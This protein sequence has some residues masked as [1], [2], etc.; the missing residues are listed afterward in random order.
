M[1]RVGWPKGEKRSVVRPSAVIV[2]TDAFAAATIAVRSSAVT[3]LEPVLV[4]VALAGF[5]VEATGVRGA[6]APTRAAVPPEARTA[7]RA[8]AATTLPSPRLLARVWR[9]GVGVEPEPAFVTGSVAV[10]LATTQGAAG[11]KRGG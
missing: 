7:A 6:R 9:V 11:S 5:C 8:A 4:V 1:P 2:T 10:A 3:V